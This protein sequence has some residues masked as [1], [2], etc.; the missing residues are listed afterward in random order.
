MK[1]FAAPKLTRFW[2]PTKNIE[3][4]PMHSNRPGAGMRDASGLH[5][6]RRANHRH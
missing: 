2:L 6:T 3:N 1:L 5:L 4:N